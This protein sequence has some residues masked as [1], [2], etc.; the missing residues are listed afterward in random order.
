ME[1]KQLFIYSGIY[2]FL[3]IA[4]EWTYIKYKLSTELTRK[5]IHIASGLIALSFPLFFTQLLS[6]AILCGMFLVIL[7]ASKPLKLLGS[8]NDV[9]RETKGST[10]FPII[11]C[12][13]FWIFQQEQIYGFYYLPI[14]ILAICD[15]IAALTGKKIGYGP[16]TIMGN[17]KTFA[18][19]LGF[20][21]SCFILTTGILFAN[22]NIVFALSVAAGISLLCTIA[23]GLSINGYDNLTI[24]LTALG[25]LYF[26]KEVIMA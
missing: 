10:I 26:V 17:K 19:N 3:F 2:L 9:E 7:Y 8:I 21:I 11:V 1:F 18:G 15:P 14:L 5:I 16:Y 6:V 20:F 24:P 13:C 12:G 22:G 25:S 23:E 4:I